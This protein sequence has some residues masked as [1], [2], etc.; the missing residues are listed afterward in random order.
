M[1]IN[2]TNY[3]F[4]PRAENSA[5]RFIVVDGVNGAGK[6]TFIKN[7]QAF[8][9][10]HNVTALFTREPGGTALGLE[11][12]RLLLENSGDSRDPL[13]EAFLFAGDRCE[14][15][16]SLVRP[17]LTKGI[18][19][20]SDRYYYSSVAF[21]GAGRQ[22]GTDLI[23]SINKIAIQDILP[24]LVFLLDLPVEIGLERTRSRNLANDSDKDSFEYEELAFHQRLRDGFLEL[25]AR[26]P[27][28]FVIVDAKV[29]PEEI[30]EQA[31]SHLVKLFSL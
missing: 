24:D 13:T 3:N 14:H 23:L 2:H 29:S 28:P 21:Q 30:F 8:L 18:S 12:R 1:I 9:A 19:V 10:Q 7:I 17:N 4:M 31:K 20:I 25:S 22:L 5:S 11:L 26:L 27:E 15:V 16:S 6:S